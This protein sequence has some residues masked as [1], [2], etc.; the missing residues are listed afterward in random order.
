MLNQLQMAKRKFETIRPDAG[1]P[2]NL[3]QAEKLAEWLENDVCGITEEL[4][5]GKHFQSL[6]RWPIDRLTRE[7]TCE[8]LRIG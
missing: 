7:N 4:V 8:E 1:S 5:R 3:F 2:K 6:A